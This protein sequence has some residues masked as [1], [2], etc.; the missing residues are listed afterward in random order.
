[1][2]RGYS[3]VSG[4]W[5]NAE[6]VSTTLPYAAGGLLSNVDDLWK[7][8]Q[9]LASGKLIAPESLAKARSEHQLA[10]GRGTGY[11]FGW[12][13]GTLHGHATVEHGGRAHGFTG[14]LLRAADAGLFVAVLSNTD[15]QSAVRPEHLATRIARSLLDDRTT[16]V[17]PAPQAVLQDYAGDYRGPNGEL[18]HFT[19]GQ[20]DLSLEDRGG[21]RPLVRT[22]DDAFLSRRDVTRFC[23]VRDDTHR[24]H[25]VLVHPRLGVELRFAR[26]TL[27]GQLPDK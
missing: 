27:Q 4:G 16:T 20:E 26:P 10:D 23:F 1:M 22:R 7:W 8:E 18:L 21:R 6:Y 15:D 9:V 14:Y 24:V 3:R 2:V 5:A 19:A 25:C 13:V 12:Q 11:G 17:S